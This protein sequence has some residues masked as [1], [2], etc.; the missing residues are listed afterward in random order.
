MKVLPLSYK[1]RPD[2][3]VA[4][5]TTKKGVK[6]YTLALNALGLKYKTE[7]FFG[8]WGGFRVHGGVRQERPKDSI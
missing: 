3:R 8:S 5:M 1:P 2:L 4:G 6:W 7:G